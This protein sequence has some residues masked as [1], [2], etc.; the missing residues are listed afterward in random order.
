MALT[1]MKVFNDFVYD[2]VTETIDQEVQKFNAAS[3]G[4]ITLT[5]KRNVGDYAMKAS[6]AAIS[7][8]VRRRNA[9]GSGSV[10]AVALAMLQNNSVKVAGGTPPIKWEPQQ[11]SWIQQNPEVAGVV[12]GEQLAMAMLQDELNSAIGAAAAAVRNVGSDVTYTV[13]SK[14]TLTLNGLNYG[15]AKFGDR[16][17]AIKAWV[18]HSK[19]FHDLLDT[20]LTNSSQL[21]QFGTVQVRQDGMGRVFIV[22]DSPNLAQ[23]IVSP[24]VYDYVTLGLVQDAIAVEDNNDFFA[25]TDTTNG[26]ENIERT[27]QAEWTFNL[28]LKG[29]T[30]DVGSGSHSPTDAVLKTGT[31]WD[32]TATSIKDTL[33]VAVVS[34]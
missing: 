18:M 22:T 30:W 27:Y 14:G 19:P 29:Y 4:T 2:S 1:D 5:S 21:F 24:D 8:L 13:G 16:S 9:Y 32:K 31:N 11:L 26:Q 28:A 20:A 3:Q 33:G 15:A 17:Q 25:N 7:G 12:I 10:N 6:F 34:R 23:H